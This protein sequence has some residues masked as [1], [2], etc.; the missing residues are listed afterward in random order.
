MDT[1]ELFRNYLQ[2]QKRYS[3]RTLELYMKSVEELYGFLSPQEGE[4]AESLLQP[5]NIRAFTA[6][7]LKTGFSPVTVNLKLSA[8]S[9]YCN[10]LVKKGLLKSNPVKK[11][12][13]PKNEKRLPGFYTADAIEGYFDYEKDTKEVGEEVFPEDFLKLRDRVLTE[14]LYCTGI[15]R[16]EAASLKLFDFD[17]KRGVVR[18]TGKGD[19]SREVPVP[20]DFSMALAGYIGLQKDFYSDN[21]GK[22]LFLTDSGQPMYLSFVN[23]IVKRELSGKAGFSGKKSP[24][25]LRHSLA[26][27]LL[28]NGADLNSIKEVLGHS[29][30]AA[31]QVYTHNSFEKLKKVFLTAHPRAKKGG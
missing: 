25:M 23:K 13:R 9:T 3:P 14:L 21:P 31:T 29:S 24:H 16:A 4:Q 15:R 19:K 11:I 28:N 1:K 26:T 10:L 17:K 5:K 8:I 27:H 30:L 18:V 2:V 6:Q 7:L 22:Y 20:D 12:H